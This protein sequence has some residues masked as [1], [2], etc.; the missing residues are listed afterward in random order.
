MRALRAKILVTFAVLMW[1]L[2]SAWGQLIPIEDTTT[3]GT[4]IGVYGADGY[5]LPGFDPATQD[6]VNLPGYVSSYAW[7]GTSR[8]QWS[9]SETALR[10][11]QDP[12]NPSNRKA[13]CAYEGG[14]ATRT[15]TL[16]LNQAQSFD[17]GLYLLDWEGGRSQTLEVPGYDPVA[18][19]NYQDPGKWYIYRVS[20]DAS[21]PVTV[22][23][24]HDGGANFVTSAI[25][26]DPVPVVAPTLIW[27]GSTD[28][29][30]STHWSGGPPTFPDETAKAQV[31]SGQ[32]TVETDHAAYSL[33]LNGGEVRIGSGNTLTLVEG[34]QAA[35]GSLLTLNSIAEL[36]S[37]RGT[38]DLLHT[39]GD[40]TVETTGDLAINTY[41]DQTIAGTMTKSGD[42]TLTLDNPANVTSSTTFQI[43]AGTLQAI[44][45]ASV[46]GSDFIL[47]GGAF[48]VVGNEV[49]VPPTGPPGAQAYYSFDD[50]GAPGNDDSGNAHHA[51]L[52]NGAAWT[53]SGFVGGAVEFDGGDDF[54]SA[55]LDV[56]E[57]QYGV[58]L[59]LQAG[60]DN[61][62]VFTVVDNDLGGSHDRNIYT[63]GGNVGGRVWSDETITT[64]GLSVSD[65]EWHHVVHT[66][67]G[68]EGGQ[69]LYVD[70]ELEASGS[71]ANS[72]FNWQQRI[73]IGYSQVAASTFFDGL[74]DEFYA[75]DRALTVDDVAALHGT[76]AFGPIDMTTANFQVT[77]DSA[78]NAIT[79]STAAFGPLTLTNGVVSTM[80]A[81][82][83]ISF[84]STTIDP[85]A[86]RVGF[87]THV[88]T[89]PGIIDGQ[90]MS[91]LIVKAGPADLVMNPANTGLDNATFDVQGRFALLDLVGVGAADLQL[92]GG[93]LILASSPGGLTVN[94]LVSGASGYSTLTAGTGGQAGAAD[95][96]SVTLANDLAL[97]GGSTRLQTTDDYSLNIP[98]VVLSGGI[99][100]VEGEFDP[101]P[102]IV[103]NVLTER[104]FDD[105][106]G[107]G[108]LDPI[109]SGAGYLARGD[110]LYEG[111]LNVDLAFNGDRW[112]NAPGNFGAMGLNGLDQIGGLWFGRMHIGAAGS[113]APLE[114]GTVT[115]AT[116]SDDGSVWW[117]DLDDSGT[118]DPAELVVNNKGWHGGQWRYGVI[119]SLSEGVYN[120]AL[121]FFEDG[122]GEWMEARFA[123]GD[124]LGQDWLMTRV[125]PGSGAQRGLWDAAISGPGPI[126]MSTLPIVV[127]GGGGINAIT[128]W[129]AAFGP[130]T[131]QSGILSTSGA[132]DGISFD[133]T[134]IDPSATLVGFD[135]ACPALPGAIEGSSANVTIV[136]Q[137]VSD[138]I[139]DS[140]GSN[141]ENAT[142]DIQGGRLITLGMGPVGPAPLHLTGGELLLASPGGDLPVSNAIVVTADSGLTAGT[143]GVG[144]PGPLDVIVNSL[145][146]QSGVLALRATD[147]YQLVIPFP[148]SAP[149]GIDIAGGIIRIPEAIDV[150]TL[151]FSGGT[152]VHPGTDDLNAGR[153]EVSNATVDLPGKTIVATE[154]HLWN[155]T[156]NTNLAGGDVYSEG[157][158]N[159]LLGP[160][161]TYTGPTVIR[162]DSVLRVLPNAANLGSNYVR[163]EWGIGLETSGTFE[164]TIGGGPGEINW[165]GGGGGF[166]AYGG[167]LAV[168][169]HTTGTPNDT[170]AMWH[171]AQGFNGQELRLNSPYSTGVVDI[172]NDLS[173]PWWFDQY[174]RVYDNP[175]T[176]TDRAR[177]SGDFVRWSPT[178]VGWFN[179]IGDGVLELTGSNTDPV[180]MRIREG[181]VRVGEDGAGL[182]AG[183]FRVY[184]DRGTQPAVLEAYGELN[185][186]L[187]WGDGE[188]VYEARGGFAAYGGPL[189]LTFNGGAELHWSW[190]PNGFRNQ[191]IVFGSA[192]ANNVVTLTNPINFDG[193]DRYLYVM[194]NPDTEDDKAVLAGTLSNIWRFQKTGNGHLVVDGPFAAGE[195]IYQ[196]HG[197]TMTVNGNVSANWL[198]FYDGSTM[199]VVDPDPLDGVAEGNLT[200][201]DQ[202]RINGVWSTL[203]VD[204]NVQARYFYMNWGEPIN[205]NVEGDF[206]IRD[207]VE[208]N[209]AGTLRV[210]GNYQTGGWVGTWLRGTNEL[211]IN[212]ADSF[213]PAIEIGG[214]TRFGGTGHF[215]VTTGDGYWQWIRF[216]NNAV[217]TPGDDGIGTFTLEG[218]GGVQMQG[219]SIYDFDIGANGETHDLVEV[220]GNLWLDS[221]WTLRLFDA[222]LGTLA[223]PGLSP[224]DELDLFTYSGDLQNLGNYLIDTSNID[225]TMYRLWNETNARILHDA[226][227]KRVYLTGLLAVPV[228]EPGTC[229]LLGA[230]LL[231]LA[232]RRRRRK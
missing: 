8:W 40:A 184:W 47:D 117:V 93:D 149:G 1:G 190:D 43:Q 210:N 54:V 112:Q 58:S 64:S 46:A 160:N 174:I 181:V 10:A 50:S 74:I 204:G 163:Y 224:D 49:G 114:E 172:T 167:D 70:G 201:N 26:F 179:K 77:D 27:D 53:G 78:I 11:V 133:G 36:A 51:T 169:L 215:R 15:L 129:G 99:L 139:L 183:N 120:V 52:M 31:D 191:E 217:L 226:E 95:A 166:S 104:L 100:E 145:D 109:D 126:D 185:M 107:D 136:K 196:R 73:N 132:T 229:V 81:P 153:F 12:A 168:T 156:V 20:G 14:N 142:F 138:L 177:I 105:V 225:L 134:T 89:D 69:K 175:S 131:L 86:T 6:V 213:S 147:D 157:G 218:L 198:E 59:W 194:D 4:W 33:A 103:P 148:L 42:A 118:F 197:G 80:G 178:E 220:L 67:G 186:N 140:M 71:K 209:G 192:T 135:T 19:T 85:G 216:P 211:I 115:L 121:G 164:R 230:G 170:I 199:N 200:I 45:P 25:M 171:D 155:A 55:L 24:T 82:D 7:P 110:Y 34:I 202:I 65:G 152:L 5:I 146:L 29:W 119:P 125:N 23:M 63:T 176:T 18:A 228:P 83:G 151:R 22:T 48:E 113:G 161:N 35:P 208:L 205:A 165:G 206:I 154:H 124:T 158:L 223:T 57:T 16:N 44:D 188:M 123:Q 173:P 84:L 56:S 76:T 39:S 159:Q 32:V 219:G 91:G 182:P 94:N 187:G 150:G 30:G 101:T 180:L 193:G 96:Q 227:G 108:N 203:N 41:N 21:N 232:R 79:D 137:G 62:G 231:A 98:S 60:S 2:G 130:L 17:L 116:N 88:T 221:T 106:Y 222:G 61:R 3:Q 68:T 13:A 122:G 128:N 97:Y 162:G 90:G 66:F 207:G 37:N 92:S 214:G 38:I 72:D 102:R 195:N 141:L 28:L 75:Y 143:G 212:G 144:V 189:D 87:D 9:G 127:D 111:G